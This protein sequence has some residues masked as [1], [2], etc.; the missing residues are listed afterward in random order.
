MI[1]VSKDS[2]A[3]HLKFAEKYDLPFVLR[4]DPGL[5]VIKA[6]GAG[7]KRSATARSAWGGAHYLH[8]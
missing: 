2:V 6:Y 8:H 3:S 4:S 1:G 7:R 5:E